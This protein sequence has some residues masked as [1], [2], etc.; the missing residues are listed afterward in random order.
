MLYAYTNPIPRESTMLEGAVFKSNRN[1][2][3]RLPQAAAF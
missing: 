3:V 2:A 1:Q